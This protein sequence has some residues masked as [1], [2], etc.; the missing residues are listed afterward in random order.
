MGTFDKSKEFA[1][2][3]RAERETPPET[4]QR[5]KASRYPTA[6]GVIR[7]GKIVT[8]N[9]HTLTCKLQ[10]WEAGAWADDGDNITVYPFEMEFDKCSNFN[11]NYVVPPFTVDDPIP[12]YKDKDEKW[13]LLRTSLYVGSTTTRSID[14]NDT[15]ERAMA[16]YK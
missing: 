4:I 2:A 5:T 6:E 12:V 9:S 8:I 15:S 11:F 1:Q 3:A 14:W 7:R 16:V 13:Y 10:K